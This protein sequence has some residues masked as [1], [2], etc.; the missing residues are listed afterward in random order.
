MGCKACASALRENIKPK[1]R[2]SDHSPE[3]DDPDQRHRVSYTQQGKHL[4][5]E[6]PTTLLAKG[7]GSNQNSLT[8]KLEKISPGSAHPPLNYD[9][10]KE[11]LKQ[12]K[13]LLVVY[14]DYA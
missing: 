13:G 12:N 8:L 10:Q 11:G 1:G 3:G 4:R 14:S 2:F 7:R 6:N 5:K 9:E